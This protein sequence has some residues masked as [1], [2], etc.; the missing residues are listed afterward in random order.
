[1]IFSSGF[2]GRIYEKKSDKNFPWIYIKMYL[3]FFLK[4]WQDF[5]PISFIDN[6]HN[7]IIRNRVDLFER[8]EKKLLKS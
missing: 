6:N 8:K 7:K 3:R 4:Q 2:F 1:M 5:T